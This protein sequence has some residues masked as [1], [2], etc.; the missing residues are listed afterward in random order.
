MPNWK[1]PCI[2][3]ITK[4]V[5]TNQK[6]LLCNT[7]KKWL[8]LKCTDL[9]DGQYEF[10]E[11]HIELPFYCLLCKPRP[12]YADLIFDNTFLSTAN[13]LPSHQTDNDL[14]ENL[15]SSVPH[16]TDDKH[17]DEILDTLSSN[18]PTIAPITRNDNSL[19]DNSCVINSDTEFSD[20]HS[21][22]FDWESDES[23]CDLRKLILLVCLF[24]ALLIQTPR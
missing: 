3:C 24:N 23:D 4:P 5:R 2:V 16:K 6:G 19:P 20:A 1:Y 11:T 10:L 13:T 9:S 17:A 18:L 7:C 15:S 12:H 14:S 22:D 8:H 21:S